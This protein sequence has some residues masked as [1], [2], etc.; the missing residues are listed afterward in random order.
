ML[1]NAFFNEFLELIIIYLYIFFIFR[2]HTT[3]HD[4]S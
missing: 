3:P 4:K 2:G 1:E